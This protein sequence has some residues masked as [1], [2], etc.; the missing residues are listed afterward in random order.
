MANDASNQAAYD[1]LAL[2]P[3]G[4][5]S[6]PS[7]PEL[8]G[9][10]ADKAVDLRAEFIPGQIAGNSYYGPLLQNYLRSLPR[11]TDDVERDFGIDIYEKMLND[12]AVSSAIQ[13]LK[14]QAL[15]SGVRFTGRVQ[16]PS[17]WQKDAAKEAAYA[18]CAAMRAFIEA[19]M[20]RLQQPLSAI[21]ADMLDCLAYGHSLAEMV[22]SAEGGTLKLTA[23]RVK[24]RYRYA[25]VTDRFLQCVGVVPTEKAAGIIPV[26]WVIP[27][28][29][30][31]HQVIFTHQSDPR[32]RSLLRP[33]YNAW[34]MKQQTWMNYLKYLLQFATP[35]VLALLDDMA[36]DGVLTD[37]H[38]NVQRGPGGQPIA[39]SAE[40]L[41]T[42]KL[43]KFANSS[44]LALRYVKQFQVLQA[45]GA[46]EP[47]LN[48]IDLY[49]RE[50]A[51]AII[52]APRALLEAQYGS[53]ADS[54]AGKDLLD[55]FTC[56]IQRETEAAFYRDVIHP[57]C[58]MHFGQADADAFAPV[59]LLSSDNQRD[60]VEYGNMVANLARAGYL[61]SSQY[62]GIDAQIGL[63]EREG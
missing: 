43:A 62:Q 47:Y 45:S 48:A 51:M 49:N 13:A 53:K 21:V 55:T 37:E 20:Q 15:S 57:L 6:A 39:Q 2:N 19:T 26:E 25:Y 3:A 18:R 14:V 7:V 17:P 52:M 34:Y 46:G 11:P 1:P 44:S 5:L 23:L 38:G 9:L 10:A 4:V 33:A 24:N 63:P 8:D 28:R 54:A 32:G 61:H 40:A 58:V 16:Q 42:A 29:K 50:M 30:F 56:Y 41:V 36:K 12:P 27:R 22:F 35:S 59:M 31:W 60:T